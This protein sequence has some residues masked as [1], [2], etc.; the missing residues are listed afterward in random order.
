LQV[1]EL[2]E[3]ALG[4]ALV[5]VE[6]ALE[7]IEAL[8]DVVKGGAESVLAETYVAVV[9]FVIEGIIDFEMVLPDVGFDSAEAADLPFVVDEGV[10]QVALARGCGV[11]LGV[12]LGGELSQGF[13]IF[14][15]DDVGLG[16][17]AGFQG[18]HAG[19]GLAGAGAGAGGFP[20]IQAIRRDL[21]FRCHK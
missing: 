19:D 3:S 17:N 13:G 21:F 4:G 12:V 1:A 20:R 6:T 9:R 5:G 16:M 2:L 15:P 7:T 14:A 10:H 18:V 11:E 8:F